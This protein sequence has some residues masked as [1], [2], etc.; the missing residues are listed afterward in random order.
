VKDFL[1]RRIVETQ[2]FPEAGILFRD[3]SPLLRHHFAQTLDA[4]DAL[5]SAE[6]WQGIDAVAGV[7]ARGFILGAALA[8]RRGLGFLPIRKAGKL[9]PPLQRLSYTLEY[10]EATLEMQQGRG[11]LLLVDDVYATGG[12]LGAAA[13]LCV[14][15]GHELRAVIVLV[16]LRL[17]GQPAR[18]GDRAVRAVLHYGGQE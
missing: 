10:A 7:D 6:E 14:A 5:L 4:L 9:P 12:T 11:R 2:D 16:D 18:I 17:T 13:D 1:K 3:I 15:S 8:A